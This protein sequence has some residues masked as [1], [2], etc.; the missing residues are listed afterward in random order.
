LFSFKFLF[1]FLL[2]IVGIFLLRMRTD[3]SDAKEDVVPEFAVETETVNRIYMIDKQGN[4]ADLKKGDQ[5]IWTFNDSFLAWSSHV[6]L[7]LNE[8]MA[9][10][11]VKNPV[12]KSARNNVLSRMAIK[13]IKVMVYDEKSPKPI[14]VYYVG[15]TTSDLLGTYFMEEGDDTPYVIHINGFNGY[16]NT[17]Y[18]LDR[19]EWISRT[20]FGSTKEQIKSVSM[21]FPTQP[22]ESYKLINT[23]GGIDVEM[24]S[25]LATNVNRGAVRS[26]LASFDQLNFE[27]YDD[28][29]S[30]TFVDSLKQ[31]SPLVIITVESDNRETDR[32]TFYPK[33]IDT[34]TKDL[35]DKEGNELAT[36]S[37]RYYA[38]YNKMDRLLIV[39]DYTFQ[40]VL[41]PYSMLLNRSK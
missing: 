2:L 22:S 35:Y 25:G 33:P 27:G 40:K 26:L 3:K 12:N 16:L 38:V 21:E 34:R 31:T 14:K 29:K 30:S 4:F 24:E 18:S 32:L 39:Q 1:F 15:G 19:D 11:S 37:D 20:I 7:L 6:D 9:K 5:G 41:V 23:A 36:D 13:A 17:R 8:T 28:L 10:L